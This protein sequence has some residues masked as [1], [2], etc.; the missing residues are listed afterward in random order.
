[1]I[2]YKLETQQGREVITK[3]GHT[4]FLAD[5]VKELNRKLHLE[6]ENKKLK[7]STKLQK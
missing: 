2:D 3:D 6:A 1:M 5:I 7:Q 4:M